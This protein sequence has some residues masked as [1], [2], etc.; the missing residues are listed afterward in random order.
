MPGTAKAAQTAHTAHTAKTNAIE[1]GPDRQLPL[2][3]SACLLDLICFIGFDGQENRF[4]QDT[5]AAVA[6]VS[7][8]FR[9][10]FA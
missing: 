1:S 10:W 6:N 8:G 3:A 9:I 5:F 7:G 4:P 2:P